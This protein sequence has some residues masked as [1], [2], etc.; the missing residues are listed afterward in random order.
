MKIITVELQIVLL[1]PPGMHG[2]GKNL[3]TL[4]DWEKF[5]KQVDQAEA[6]TLSEN[7]PESTGLSQCSSIFSTKRH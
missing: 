4:N 1:L 6:M 7:D 3:R 2:G 5:A